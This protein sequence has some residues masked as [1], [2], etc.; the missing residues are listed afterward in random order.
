M[1][2][3]PEASVTNIFKSLSM[4][5][6]KPR[7]GLEEKNDPHNNNEQRAFFVAT[8]QQQTRTITETRRSVR[9]P[10]LLDV[11]SCFLPRIPPNRDRGNALR[12]KRG[13]IEEWLKRYPIQRPSQTFPTNPSTHS[14]GECQPKY[15]EAIVTTQRST[16]QFRGYRCPMTSKIVGSTSSTINQGQID[17]TKH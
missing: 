2:G 13:L 3:Y 5:A 6:C 11:R 10:H 8:T 9:Q 12:W 7:S 4:S 14:R 17:Q 1:V 15:L 16:H